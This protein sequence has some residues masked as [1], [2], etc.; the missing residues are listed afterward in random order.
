MR[1]KPFLKWSEG[2]APAVASSR[3]NRS[4]EVPGKHFRFGY[5]SSYQ[6][7]QRKGAK[8]GP[9]FPII[10]HV[11]SGFGMISAKFPEMNML[12]QSNMGTKQ[13]VHRGSR[14]A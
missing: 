2:N 3:Q 1:G 8:G 6:S 7:L 5:S 14:P 13:F 10:C 11:K 4:I 9:S 12:R